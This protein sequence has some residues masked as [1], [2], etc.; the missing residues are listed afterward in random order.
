MSQCSI[1]YG[2]ELRGEVEAESSSGILL[3]GGVET[4]NENAHTT[5]DA[6]NLELQLKKSCMLEKERTSHGMR[7]LTSVRAIIKNDPDLF[8]RVCKAENLQK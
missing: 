3:K 2:Q 1:H 8:F 7:C 6:L 5:S 4:E